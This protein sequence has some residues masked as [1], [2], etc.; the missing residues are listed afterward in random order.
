MIHHCTVYRKDTGEIVQY[1]NFMCGEDIEQISRNFFGRLQFFGATDHDYVEFPSDP[2]TDYVAVMGEQVVIAQRPE[3][4]VF[5][6]DDKLE[7]RAGGEDSTTLTGLPD[8]CQIIVDDP[9][10]AVETQ[11]YDV[12]GGGFIFEADDPG[13]Y[14][15]EVRR[16]PFLPFKI[17]ITAT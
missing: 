4:I 12:T 1:S 6:E 2:E 3:L 16:F 11:T 15:I 10:P 9:D 8:P 5:V 7:I 17:E 14:T 13:V